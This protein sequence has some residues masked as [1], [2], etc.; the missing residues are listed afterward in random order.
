MDEAV[1]LKLRQQEPLHLI[2]G[3]KVYQRMTKLTQNPK[4]NGFEVKREIFYLQLHILTSF[5]IVSSSDIFCGK[6]EKS[7]L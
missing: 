2:T 3:R 7:R 6:Y 4:S 1:I 5:K